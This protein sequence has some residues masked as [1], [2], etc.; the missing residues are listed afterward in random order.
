VEKRFGGGA[1]VVRDISVPLLPARK[2]IRVTA[3]SRRRAAREALPKKLD[4]LRRAQFL[5]G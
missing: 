1:R 4:G 5:P 2:E 3:H